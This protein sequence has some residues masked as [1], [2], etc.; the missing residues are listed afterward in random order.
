MLVQRTKG[1]CE[2]SIWN[3]NDMLVKLTFRRPFLCPS[4]K[5]RLLSLNQQVMSPSA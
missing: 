1:E 5:V 2:Y 4:K 3:T